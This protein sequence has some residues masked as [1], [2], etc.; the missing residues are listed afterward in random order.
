MT[1]DK[2]VSDGAEDCNLPELKGSRR[3]ESGASREADLGPTGQ[4]NALV[5]ERAERAKKAAKV[6][7]G[8]FVNLCRTGASFPLS[9]EARA[10]RRSVH[11]AVTQGLAE[12]IDILLPTG[13]GV[14]IARSCT[15]RHQPAA[16]RVLVNGRVRRLAARCAPARRW[17]IGPTRAA[18]GPSST[19][20]PGA[21]APWDGRPDGRAPRRAAS[22]GP[23]PPRLRQPPGGSRRDRGVASTSR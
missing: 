1:G 4:R 7:D 5:P 17:S 23:H 10:Q 21:P 15:S 13:H 3:C 14:A 16:P 2:G 12:E 9:S 18:A 8:R 20:P 22:R 6:R 19:R 11:E